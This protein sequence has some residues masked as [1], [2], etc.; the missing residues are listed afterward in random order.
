VA[1]SRLCWSLWSVVPRGEDTINRTSRLITSRTYMM[2]IY[3]VSTTG[4]SPEYTLMANTTHKQIM[5]VLEG[6][7]WLVLLMAITWKTGRRVGHRL[8][9]WGKG[10]VR[11][12]VSYVKGLNKLSREGGLTVR[13]RKLVGRK[14]GRAWLVVWARQECILTWSIR[15]LAPLPKRKRK[16]RSNVVGRD[17]PLQSQRA[18]MERGR[19]GCRIARMRWWLEWQAQGMEKEER[20]EL[21]KGGE[22]KKGKGEGKRELIQQDKRK[23]KRQTQKRWWEGVPWMT[24]V[25]M[26]KLVQKWGGE[27][28]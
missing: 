26:T 24:S 19:K 5:W 9:K 16:G 22:R 14:R 8:G 25:K 23:T 12:C 15:E 21:L 28:R 13:V 18:D 3:I 2:C 4:V 10:V 11:G 7:S 1:K 27:G 6:I 20:T 17:R